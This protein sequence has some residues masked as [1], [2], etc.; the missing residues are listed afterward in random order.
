MMKRRVGASE[1]RRADSEREE[2]E[3]APLHARIE[4]MLTEARVILP[5]AQALLGFQ[6]VIV[7]TSAFDKLP[8]TS[9]LLHGAA[10]LCVTLAV[11]LLI[12]PAALHRIVWAGQDSEALLQIGGRVTISALLPLALGM[13]GDAYVVFTRIAGSSG[14]GSGAAALV[15]AGLFGLWFAW[16]VAAR[17]KQCLAGTEAA[18]IR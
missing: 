4:Q 12:T 7:L 10:L 13:A 1:R 6:L 3:G 5:G 11:I 18:K 8:E 2:R 17:R 15:A 16:P 9:R 14:F